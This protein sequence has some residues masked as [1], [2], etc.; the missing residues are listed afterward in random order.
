[1]LEVLEKILPNWPPTP[2]QKGYLPQL[3]RRQPT[4]ALPKL[5][6]NHTSRKP[7]KAILRPTGSLKGYPAISY[8]KFPSLSLQKVRRPRN[9]GSL[10]ALQLSQTCSEALPW[11]AH[12]Q[13]QRAF[14]TGIVM[15]GTRIL[16]MELTLSQ[17]HWS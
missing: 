10:L 11:V 17:R 4:N 15:T 3:G 5:N 1:M 14:L 16:E 12:D 6:W 13:V 9:L 8:K 7:P 2:S